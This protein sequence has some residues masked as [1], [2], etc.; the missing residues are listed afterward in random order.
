MSESDPKTTLTQAE[1]VAQIRSAMD[2]TVGKV[3]LGRQVWRDAMLEQ[4]LHSFAERIAEQLRLCGIHLVK[5][6]PAPPWC[7]RFADPDP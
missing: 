4:G 2:L 3:K 1:A 5:D 6:P 7:G